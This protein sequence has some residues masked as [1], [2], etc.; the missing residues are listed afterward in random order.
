MDM[1]TI[2][3]TKRYKELSYRHLKL[4]QLYSVMSELRLHTNKAVNINTSSYY[5]N[6]LYVWGDYGAFLTA[7]MESMMQVFYI[8]LDGF[9]GAFW[10]LGQGRVR[11]R[12]H[13]QGSLA[14][15]LYDET[16]ITR[17]RSAREAFEA[18]LK[19]EAD[20]LEMIHNLR[21]KLAH[22]KKLGERNEALAPGDA[23]TREILNKLA[24]ILYL[25]GFQRWNEPHYIQQDDAP[26]ESTQKVIDRLVGLDD[27]SKNVRKDYLEARNSWFNK[28]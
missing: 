17:K 26:S 12:N 18:L 7:S 10:N 27:R 13:D 4:L 19:N 28:H 16:R 3:M 25:L 20:S 24:E 9:I 15:Y 14:E 11:L 21:G 1:P 8:E 23:K 22:F 2:A 5:H 6:K